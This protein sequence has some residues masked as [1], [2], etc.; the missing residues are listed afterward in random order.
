MQKQIRKEFNNDPHST[1]FTTKM[2]EGVDL[3]H[4]Q[5]KILVPSTLKMRVLDWYHNILVHPGEKRMEESIQSLYAWK[6][7]RT[8]ILQYCRTCEICQRCKKTRKQK[9]GFLPKKWE[10]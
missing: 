8:D 4:T 5:D 3:V 10:R 2:V 9:Y 6:D 7:L 1:R